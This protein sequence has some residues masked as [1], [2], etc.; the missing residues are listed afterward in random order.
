MWAASGGAVWARHRTTGA[1][2]EVSTACSAGP[3]RA[4]RRAAARSRTITASGLAGRCLRRRS[5]ATAAAFR[6]SHTSW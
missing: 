3:I 1:A 6:A 2:G 4:S 5:P